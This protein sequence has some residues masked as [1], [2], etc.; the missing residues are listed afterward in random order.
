MTV[1][2]RAQIQLA[3]TKEGVATVEKIKEDLGKQLESLLK[4]WRKKL[5]S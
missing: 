5:G 2:M 3:P 4:A 1:N